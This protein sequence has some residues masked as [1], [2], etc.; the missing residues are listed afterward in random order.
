MNNPMETHG[1]TLAGIRT[2]IESRGGTGAFRGLSFAALLKC[3]I[4]CGQ[5][6]THAI[7]P[8]ISILL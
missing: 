6:C 3:R 8:E 4:R 1:I 5:F 2:F 7:N